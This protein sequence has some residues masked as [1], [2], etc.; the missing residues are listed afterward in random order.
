[1][2][3][4]DPVPRERVAHAHPPTTPIPQA[5]HPLLDIPGKPDTHGARGIGG[6]PLSINHA[7]PAWTNRQ[8]NTLLTPF[9]HPRPT[10]RDALT[11]I[12][13]ANPPWI[14][15]RSRGRRVVEPP[16]TFGSSYR[17]SRLSVL[18]N[19][20]PVP[21][22]RAGH[23]HSPTTSIH[24][25]HPLRHPTPTPVIASTHTRHPNPSLVISSTHTCHPERSRGI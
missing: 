9:H 11:Y 20:D 15:D 6:A 18:P 14:P 16:P 19:S 10:G 22:E 5:T 24:Q 17:P 12:H 23:P 1:M 8:T 4:S 13:P 21:R 3:D 7:Q 25:A 2:P